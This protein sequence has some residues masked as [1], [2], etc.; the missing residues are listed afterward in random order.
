MNSEGL[1]SRIARLLAANVHALVG[2]IESRTPLAVLEQYLREFDEV[3]GRARVHLGRHEAARYQ[4]TKAIARVN[5]EIG[6]LDAQ[7]A[8]ALRSGEEALA[9][10]GAA[11][12]IELEDSLVL[13]HQRLQETV[14]RT[15]AAE[16]ELLAL[17]AKREEMELALSDLLAARA[18]ASLHPAAPSA[19]SA[20]AQQLG[21]GFS[22]A[23]AGASGLPAGGAAPAQ[24]DAASLRQ[25]DALLKEQR[26]SERLERLRTRQGSAAA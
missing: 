6:R 7:I 13:L 3:I 5:D 14:E 4:S 25:L 21:L 11:R 23:M 22:R 20:R 16:A 8:V 18:S 12:Q 15:G 26:V 24:A 9:R 19:P 1:H 17:R 2:S 10:T